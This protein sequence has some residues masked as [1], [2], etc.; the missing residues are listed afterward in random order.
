M[1]SIFEECIRGVNSH[2]IALRFAVNRRGN[3]KE[4]PFCCPQSDE[5]VKSYAMAS[6]RLVTFVW[7]LSAELT[8]QLSQCQWQHMCILKLMQV[9]LSASCT[10]YLL[11][12]HYDHMGSAQQDDYLWTSPPVGSCRRRSHFPSTADSS[13]SLVHSTLLCA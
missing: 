4:K 5:P 7:K 11:L 2:P 8:Q 13:Q 3:G 10:M 6:T 9:H 12:Q 1:R